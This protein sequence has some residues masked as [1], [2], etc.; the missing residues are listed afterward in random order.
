MHKLPKDGAVTFAKLTQYQKVEN[1][2]FK[3]V[4]ILL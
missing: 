1:S 4:F 2:S 3:K